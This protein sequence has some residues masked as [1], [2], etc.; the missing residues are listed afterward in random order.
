MAKKITKKESGI[1]NVR[2]SGV[3]S[4]V[5]YVSEKLFDG[6]VGV[7]EE[8]PNGKQIT[9]YI[10]CKW[11]NPSVELDKGDTVDIT[12]KFGTDSYEAKDGKKK[13]STIVIIES[14]EVFEA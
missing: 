1:N 11:F 12:G 10:R 13:Y 4:I 5:N 6:T 14:L 3:V 8:T 9:H 7:T 2:I